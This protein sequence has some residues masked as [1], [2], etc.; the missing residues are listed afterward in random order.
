MQTNPEQ[1][2]MPAEANDSRTASD[3]A[4]VCKELLGHVALDRNLLRA[5]G[6]S[7]ES[8]KIVL[9]H[10]TELRAE[11]ERVKRSMN[12][13]IVEHLKNIETH[14]DA[15]MTIPAKEQNIGNIQAVV[16]IALLEIKRCLE[17]IAIANERVS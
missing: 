5:L 2:A 17:A 4:V 15:L 11:I 13:K 14:A 6:L 1:S 9:D 3:E 16:S 12:D 10:I 7:S 8:S